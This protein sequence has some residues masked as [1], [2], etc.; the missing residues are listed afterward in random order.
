[1]INQ[2][3]ITV[4]VTDDVYPDATTIDV[5]TTDGQEIYNINKVLPKAFFW[6]NYE[7]AVDSILE[8]MRI[9]AKKREMLKLNDENGGEDSE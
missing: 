6:S 4:T 7:S 1:M 5:Q 8:E 9:Y 3:K 2:L